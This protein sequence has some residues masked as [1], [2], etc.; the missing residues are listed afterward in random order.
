MTA[1]T[2]IGSPSTMRKR[3]SREEEDKLGFIKFIIHNMLIN[4]GDEMILQT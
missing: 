1:I 4:W 3:M 2:P